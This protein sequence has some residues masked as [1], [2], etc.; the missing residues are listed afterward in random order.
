MESKNLQKD[1]N[2]FMK[3]SLMKI[4]ECLFIALVLILKVHLKN[5]NFLIELVEIQQKKK[6]HAGSMRRGVCDRTSLHD[7]S[8]SLKRTLQVNTEKEPNKYKKY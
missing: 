1:I 3:F 7:P 2:L 8:K 5:D 6:E 4:K